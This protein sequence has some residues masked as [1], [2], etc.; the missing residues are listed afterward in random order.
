MLTPTVS[1]PSRANAVMASPCTTQWMQSDDMSSQ[2]RQML[3]AMSSF[4][5][6]CW[7]RLPRWSLDN[8]VNSMLEQHMCL[9]S[10]AQSKLRSHSTRTCGMDGLAA[11]QSSSLSIPASPMPSAGSFDLLCGVA[12]CRSDTRSSAGALPLELKIAEP[13]DDQPTW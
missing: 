8:V 1:W 12:V 13:V 4:Q 9:L 2:I 3:D 5:E 11:S 6:P 10:I 7:G